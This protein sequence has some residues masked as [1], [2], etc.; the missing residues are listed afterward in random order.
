MLQKVL[1]ILQAVSAVFLVVSIIIQER[2]GGL[3]ESIAG[4]AGANAIQTTKRGA[5]KVLSYLT[6]AFLLAF[7]LLSLVLNFV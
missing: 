3:S 6:V 1:M 7:V 2:D 5:E 4:S